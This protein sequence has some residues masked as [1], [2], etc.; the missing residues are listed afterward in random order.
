MNVYFLQ[1]HSALMSRVY[2]VVVSSVI[3]LFIFVALTISSVMYT[4]SSILWLCLYY[5]F[6]WKL[7][8]LLWIIWCSW[9]KCEPK[10]LFQSSISEYCY[11]VDKKRSGYGHTKW[12]FCKNT[13]GRCPS[14]SKGGRW[15]GSED[16]D[17]P[18]SWTLD[19]FPQEL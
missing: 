17:P 7:F 16:S 12:R 19:H 18:D 6:V 8:L 9:Q 2:T 14:I 11:Y 1:I 15:W 4:L 10:F 13:G 5:S 3:F